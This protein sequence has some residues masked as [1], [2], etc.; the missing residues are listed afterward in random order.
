MWVCVPK[1][2][3]VA[4]KI[5]VIIMMILMIH[6]SNHLFILTGICG[7]CQKIG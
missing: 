5:M 7:L 1:D 6:L 3:L 4:R 2:E